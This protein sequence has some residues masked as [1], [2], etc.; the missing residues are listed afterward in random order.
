MA[1]SRPVIVLL[2]AGVLAGIV[3]T[4]GAIT[5]L[6]SDQELIAVGVAPL[7]AGVANI[8]ALTMTW[9]GSALASRRELI[10]Q[11]A[12]LRRFA[13]VAAVGGAIGTTLLLSTPAGVFASVVPFLVLIGSFALLVSPRLTSRRG[14]S[15]PGGQTGD[16]VGGRPGGRDR[17]AIAAGVLVIS[18][19]NGYFGAGAGVML[20]ALCLVTAD[21]RLPTANALK[22]MLVGAATIAAAIGLV[23]FGRVDWSAVVP[24]GIGMFVGSTI[25]PRV[26][27]RLPPG[28]L[29]PLVAAVG[30]GLAVQLWLSHG[31]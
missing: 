15:T 28:V 19:Y 14:A 17:Y 10:G 11:G 16:G 26:T 13:P 4:A 1:C 9:P 20:L 3:G 25:G 7:A 8:V 22:N 5:S 6:V 27:R 23:C 2:C 30:V 21:D 24:L 18:I 29:R 12:W 31:A